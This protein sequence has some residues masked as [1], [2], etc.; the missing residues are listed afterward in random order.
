[1]FIKNGSILIKLVKKLALSSF[2][3]VVAGIVVLTYGK[4]LILKKALGIFIILFVLNSLRN[5]TLPVTKM[6]HLFGFMGGF[7]QD[8]LWSYIC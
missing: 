8:Y 7:S 5:K 4:P 1:M 3:G 2:I 6:K